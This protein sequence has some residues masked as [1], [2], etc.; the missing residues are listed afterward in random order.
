M[1]GIGGII[2][3]KQRQ[4]GLIRKMADALSHRGPDARGLHEEGRVHLA[5]LRL[6]ILDTSSRGNQPMYSA[7][8]RL[9]MVF[10]GEVYNFRELR[11]QLPDRIWKTETDTEVILAAYEH[12]GVRCAEHFNGMFAMAIWDRDREELFLARD[13]MGIKPLYYH[14]DGEHFAFA[15]EVRALLV[16]PWVAKE[17]NRGA[18]ANYFIYQTAYGS[19]T[20]VRDVHLM[21]AGCRAVLKVREAELRGRG[22]GPFVEEKY[23]GPGRQGKVW[24]GGPDETRKEVRRLLRDAVERRMISDVPLGAFLSGGID[25]SAV[26]GLMS[27]VSTAPVDTFSVVFEE[28]EYDESVY[29]QMIAQKFNTRH[30]PILLKPSDFLDA[31]PAALQAMDHPSGDGINSYVVSEVTRNQGI[32]VALSGLGGDELFA[33]YPIFTQLPEIMKSGVWKVPRR[34]RRLLAGG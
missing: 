10:N 27:E 32:K 33:G 24:E 3:F 14:F 22:Q 15:S 13:R 16:L 25:S 21:G 20:L 26:V 17:I 18:L 4:P 34:A 30:H 1:C 8:G 2:D 9:T 5:H 6:S 7:D 12:W 31:L 29:S 19:D 11:R 28:K 23:W